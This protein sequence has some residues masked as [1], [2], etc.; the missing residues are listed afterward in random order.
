MDPAGAKWEEG[1]AER[2]LWEGACCWGPPLK[3]R[4][5]NVGVLLGGAPNAGALLAGCWA[6]KVNELLLPNVGVLEG[7]PNVG[8]L[9]AAPNAGVLEGAPNEGAL[10]IEDGAPK[11]GVE[12]GAL[13]VEVEPVNSAQRDDTG[14]RKGGVSASRL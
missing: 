10:G 13:K 7:A 12:D 4:E 6:P 3:V 9:E 1:A 14:L 11:L 5:P 2:E 8:V